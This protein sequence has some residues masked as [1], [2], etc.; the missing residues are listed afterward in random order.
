MTG[1]PTDDDSLARLPT[2][3]GVYMM[4][5]AKGR[6][7]YVGKAINLRSRVRSYFRE[8]G[9]GRFLVPYLRD[10]T[11]TVET[12]ITDNEKEALLLE[13]TLI[14]KHK[15]RF[16]IRLRDDKTYIS[17]RLDTTHKWPRLHRV[18]RRRRG[19]KALYFGP[20]SSSK[21][22]TETMRFLQRLFP[23]RSCSDAELQRRVRPCILHQIDRCCAP[24]VHQVDPAVYARYVEQTMQFLRGRRDDVIQLLRAKMDEYSEELLFEKAAMVRDRMNAMQGTVEE[25]KV[26]SHRVFDRDVMAFVRS[27]GRMVFEVISFRQG[28]L[29]ETRAFVV[30]DTDLEDAE[31]LEQFLSQFYDTTRNV[32]LDILVP[33]EPANREFLE[34][35]LRS[36][37][38]GPVHLRVPLRGVKR[39]LI[40]MAA[41]NARAELERAVSGAKSVA[42]TLESLQ[43][44][45][46]LPRPPRVIHCFDISTFQGSFPVGSMVCFRDGEP[47][48]N[49]YRRFKIRTVEGQ[50]DFAMMREV[51]T[52]QYSRAARG[53]GEKPDLTVIDGGI[54]QL[55]IAVEVLGELGLTDDFPVVGLAKSRLKD[56][57][58]EE[59]ERTQERVFLPGR[60]NP[61]VFRRSDP[62]LHLLER[63]RDETHRF[64]V[65][66]HR[67]LRSRSALRSGLEEI[68][69]VGKKRAA[70]LLKH[71][72]SLARIKAATID[73]L[74]AAPG[75]P[76]K[77][78]E[79]VHAFFHAAPATDHHTD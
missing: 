66:Y 22:V 7:L 29:D 53:E 23:L 41:Q 54:A 57:G 40:E 48:K 42:E 62:A 30:R 76:M 36:Q 38:G 20:Y 52:R 11:E 10:R 35:M 67:L 9:D 70:Q 65:T 31:A 75:V 32:P 2:S 26:Y 64:A 17:L 14:K 39:R 59:K 4:L 63:V 13:N 77:V 78:A 16:N 55:N 5:D 24:C 44:M 73:E 27:A 46:G 50:N 1:I 45:L 51:L 25:S 8:G 43:S 61:V 72:G 58:T 34:E 79:Q 6:V 68:P 18:R 47:D 12:F 56:R 33:F 15:P 37:R 71:F 28:R 19:D 69:G 60:K 74:A 49:N 21:D 3:P